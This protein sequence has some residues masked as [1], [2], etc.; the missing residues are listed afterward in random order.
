MAEERYQHQRI[1]DYIQGILSPD[2]RRRFESDL[3][4]DAQLQENYRLQLMEHEAMDHM[5]GLDLKDRFSR[6]KDDPPVDPGP[7]LPSPAGPGRG[8]LILLAALA[9]LALL[10]LMLYYTSKEAGKAGGPDHN[11]GIPDTAVWKNR[12]INSRDTFSTGQDEPKIEDPPGRNIR[13]NISRDMQKQ[14]PEDS[15]DRY[16]VAYARIA[17]DFYQEP[18]DLY[19]GLRSQKDGPQDNFGK[20]VGLFRTGK[21]RESL[22]LL[23]GIPGQPNSNVQYLK[24]HNFFR[25]GRYDEAAAVWAPLAKD[26]MLPVYEDA[27]WNLFLGYTAMLPGSKGRWELLRMALS[28]DQN[29][30]Y[31]IQLV[32]ILAKLK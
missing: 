29:F 24:G 22:T 30:N 3:K 17:N 5:I 11:P 27:R 23:E 7:A 18:E 16:D 12:E 20:A 28:K 31:K 19:A 21:Y 25:L 14:D 8:R 15:D 1:E 9:I 4:N 6:W 26:P 10:A 32:D 2:E 13:E